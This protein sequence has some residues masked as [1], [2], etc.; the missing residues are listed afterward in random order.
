MAKGITRVLFIFIVAV[1]VVSCDMTT[2]NDTQT[3]RFSGTVRSSV[4]GQPI[5]GAVVS[6]DQAFF[7]FQGSVTSDT[8]D[9]NGQY[10]IEY[11]ARCKR[12]T[13]LYEAPGKAYLLVARAIGY[14]N[15][16]NMNMGA[17]IRCTSTGQTVNFNLSPG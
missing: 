16:S 11:E 15:Q 8:I 6:L 10:R 1:C 4:T 17:S 12:N 3:L 5:P 13:D 2:D 7:V 14:M 9:N